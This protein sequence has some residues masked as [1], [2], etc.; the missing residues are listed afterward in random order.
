[1]GL[2]GSGI[3]EENHIV[4]YTHSDDYVVPCTIIVFR[5]TIIHL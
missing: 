2:S 3:D 4:L 1:M 5:M